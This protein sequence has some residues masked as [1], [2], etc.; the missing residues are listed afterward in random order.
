VAV[1]NGPPGARRVRRQKPCE[2][3]LSTDV[4]DLPLR[5]VLIL[6]AFVVPTDKHAAA[7]LTRSSAVTR[8]GTIVLPRLRDL[9]ERLPGLIASRQSAAL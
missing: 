8:L 2:G 5:A 7:Q 3:T 6:L 1:D 9:N 4:S